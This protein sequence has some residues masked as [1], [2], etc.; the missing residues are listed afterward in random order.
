M[1]AMPSAKST[2]E[3]AR[4]GA[5]AALVDMGFERSAATVALDAAGGCAFLIVVTSATP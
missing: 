3:D 2:S 1:A 4:A 5:V